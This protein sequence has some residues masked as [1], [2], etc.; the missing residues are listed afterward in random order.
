MARK[1]VTQRQA[2]FYQLYDN[3]SKD[4][5]QYIPIWQLIGEVYVREKGV[6]A[7]VSYEVSARMS[8]LYSMN[9]NLFER[10]LVTGKTGAKYNAY[11]IA[12][13]VKPEDIVD[14]DLSVFY[15]SIKRTRDYEKAQRGEI[16]RGGS[17]AK[18]IAETIR[19][20]G[21]VVSDEMRDSNGEDNDA[22]P[23]S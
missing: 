2:I 15:K 20:R 10:K 18:S 19:E 1:K 12:R 3:R 5:E 16:P 22:Q 17:D 8:E 9:P 13:N 6:W 4:P 23:V 11:R 14:P 21:G 7:F